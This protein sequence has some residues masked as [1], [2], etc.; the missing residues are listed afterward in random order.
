MS[1]LASAALQPSGAS[2]E[3]VASVAQGSRDPGDHAHLT[4]PSIALVQWWRPWALAIPQQDLASLAS[5]R[6]EGDPDHAEASILEELAAT[7]PRSWH[8]P[9]AADIGQLARRFAK[10]A[11]CAEIALRLERVDGDACHRFH[12]DY[13]PLRLI[14]TYAGSGTEWRLANDPD[15]AV[16]RMKAGHVGLFKGRGTGPVGL[17]HRSPPIAGTGES[18]LM[19]VVDALIEDDHLSRETGR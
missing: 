17:L 19:L 13:V 1:V 18:R 10:I 16:H 3:P 4:K 12:S 9:L 2:P 7:P 14:T 15:T 8:R 6:L 11:A 5:I